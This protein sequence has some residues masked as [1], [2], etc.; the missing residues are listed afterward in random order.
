MD[1]LSLLHNGYRV[2]PGSKVVEAWL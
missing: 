1:L 2:F